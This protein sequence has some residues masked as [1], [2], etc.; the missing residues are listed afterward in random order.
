[1]EP[2]EPTVAPLAALPPDEQEAELGSNERTRSANEALRALARTARSFQL[3]DPSN[4]A[5]RAFLEE[6]RDNFND[7]TTNHGD[8]VL[9]IRPFEMVLSPEMEVVYLERDRERSLAF[10]LFRD[11]VRNLVIK[12]A[13]PWSELLHLLEI[14][15][16][17]YT[18]ISH[19]EDDVVTLLWK[20]NFKHIDIEAV[21]GFVPEDEVED[22]GLGLEIAHERLSAHAEVRIPP[23]FDLPEPRLRGESEPGYRRVPE[24]KLRELR[25]E[26]SSQHLPNDCLSLVSE[27][28]AVVQEPTDPIKLSEARPLLNE[29]RDFLL[30]EG[31]LDN[32]LRMLDLMQAA[33]E[34]MGDDPDVQIL[35]NSFA[36][37]N[38][39]ARLVHSVPPDAESV[40]ESFLK[41]LDQLPGDHLATIVDLLEIERSARSRQT[42]RQLIARELPERAPYIIQRLRSAYGVVAADLFRAVTVGSP[43]DA[44]KL[45]LEL[46]DSSDMDIL[47]ECCHVV[48][49]TG[50]NATT[51]AVAFKLLHSHEEMVRIRT[52]QGVGSQGDRRMFP[53][54]ARHAKERSGGRLRIDEA[55]V[56]GEVMAG[57]DQNASLAAFKDWCLPKGFLGRV[58]GRDT[59]L[60]WAAVIGL[61]KVDSD[62]ADDVLKQIASLNREDEELYNQAVQSRVRRRQR[63]N[64]ASAADSGA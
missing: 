7:F 30:S 22:D 54:L 2:T 28:L 40:P 13:V 57:L 32:L 47:F 59:A 5:I 48:E 6:V 17:R 43:E 50:Y 56:I 25:S 9:A 35:V 44:Q 4:D 64:E 53:A 24:S 62:E 41:L 8:L 63:I 23:N 26:E 14:L 37:R 58:R 18:G 49:L 19:S 3:Y 16:I 39:L 10:R 61:Q 15:S 1:M 12:P 45:A 29:I 46:S 27:L 21:E 20:A 42:I 38:A 31:Q 60:S 11:G 34:G 51:R 36:D 55:K 33:L 52:I